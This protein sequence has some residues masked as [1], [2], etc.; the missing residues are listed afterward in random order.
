MKIAVFLACSLSVLPALAQSHRI[1]VKR[2]AYAY[3]IVDSIPGRVS[4]DA[5][6]SE[7]AQ[8]LAEKRAASTEFI[9][10]VRSACLSFQ[11]GRQTAKEFATLFDDEITKRN[12]SVSSAYQRMSDRLSAA[13]LSVLRETVTEADRQ[14]ADLVAADVVAVAPVEAERIFE[15]ICNSA[16]TATAR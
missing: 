6:R 16:T 11:K 13:G 3:E 4:L 15:V 14:S 2:A 5:D 8:F 1:N 12:G 9:K 10:G 7:I